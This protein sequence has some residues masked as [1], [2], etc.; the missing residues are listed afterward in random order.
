MKWD[1]QYALMMV[2]SDCECCEWANSA[3][4]FLPTLGASKA[5]SYWNTM[6]VSWDYVLKYIL[7][8]DAGV[9]KVRPWSSYSYCE[10][11]N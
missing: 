2:L 11:G 3:P 1:R 10:V 9:G 5:T 6:S 7:V 8:G 4:S